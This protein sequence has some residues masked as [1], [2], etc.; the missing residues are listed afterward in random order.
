M[1]PLVA[2]AGPIYTRHTDEPSRHRT[3]GNGSSLR[4]AKAL[5]P[6]HNLDAE[7]SVLGAILLTDRSLYALVIEEGLQPADFYH[8]RHGL[9]Y[10]A[11]L[12][13]YEESRAGRRAHR[14]GA[15]RSAADGSRTSAAPA[16]WTSSRASCRPRATR[17]A[18]PRS[19]ARTR[20]C[21]GC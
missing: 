18:T 10:E 14:D 15:P 3:I 2:S 12:S 21:A 20:F 11:M 8:E 4:P 7:Q 6:P 19:C 13:L 16:P 17:A 9:I 5:V 1:T